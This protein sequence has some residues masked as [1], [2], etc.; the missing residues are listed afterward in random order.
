MRIRLTGTRTACE[1]WVTRLRQAPGVEVV[2]VS[3]WYPGRG[4][5]LLGRVY[6][7][8]RPTQTPD[9]ARD[10]D[11]LPA[12]PCG[13][14]LIAG[15]HGLLVLEALEYLAAAAHARASEV[16]QALAALGGWH[17][18]DAQDDCPPQCP[19]GQGRVDGQENPQ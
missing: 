1:Q 16:N 3:G 8:A 18:H 2:Q 10:T 15:P 11:A 19:A 17:T 4:T 5:S 7:D 13:G 12:C 9:P 14:C 6:L